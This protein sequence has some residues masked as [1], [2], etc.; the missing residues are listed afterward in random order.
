MSKSEH[1][2]NQQRE[3]FISKAIPKIVGK[4]TLN[5][6]SIS[7]INDKDKREGIEL[8]QKDFQIEIKKYDENNSMNINSYEIIASNGDFGINSVIQIENESYKNKILQKVEIQR[9]Y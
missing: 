5:Y 4:F 3:F 1:Y 7:F 2:K 8:F 9:G 6:F